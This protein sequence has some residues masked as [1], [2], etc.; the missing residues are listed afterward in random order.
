MSNHSF[1]SRIKDA[2]ISRFLKYVPDNRIRVESVIRSDDRVSDKIVYQSRSL[3]VETLNTWKQA[4]MLASDPVSP[5]RQPLAENYQSLMLDNHLSSCIETRVLR[6]QRSAFLL[7]SEAT[8]EVNDDLRP[9]FQ[10]PWFEDFLE[11]SCRQIFEGTKLLELTDLNEQLH[12]TRIT[13]IPIINVNPQK[14][15]IL[16]N[17]GDTSGWMYKEGY[18]KDYYLQ[19]GENNHLGMLADVGPVVIF[20]KTAFGAWLDYI[21]K[22]GIPPRWVTTESMDSKRIR[23]L[24]VMMQN[25]ISGHWAVLQGNEK[26]ELADTPG[27]DA[28]QVFDMLIERI[29]SELSKKILGAT[30][31]TD[32]KSFVGSAKVHQ[33]IANDR[34]EAD[35]TRI[36]YII[37]QELIPR[38]IKISP[39]YSPLAGHY[40]D[41]DDSYEIEPSQLI[42][43]AVMLSNAGFELDYEYIEKRTGVKIKGLKPSGGGLAAPEKKP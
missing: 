5:N 30:G 13:E 4:L 26:I 6:V 33:Q 14:G 20:K 32:E 39:V 24:E 43:K 17:P 18:L 38:L 31:T 23:Q 11:L 40:F 15:L 9:L 12:L 35:K 1:M 36:K 37:N 19:I 21:E 10:R 41:W 3:R 2:A 7:R 42:D 34:H 28:N 16:K 25:M 22:Y 29:N 8:N 27:T